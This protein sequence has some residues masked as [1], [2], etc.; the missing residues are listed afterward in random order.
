MVRK[1]RNRNS[2]GS[3]VLMVSGLLLIL[4]AIGWY[5]FSGALR[6][7]GAA[8]ITPTNEDNYPQIARI[9]PEDAKRAYDQGAAIFLDVRSVEEYNQERIRGALSI[10]LLELPERLGELDPNIWY[11]TYC[12]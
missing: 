3:L 12:T 1:K 8:Q 10:P 5:L 2:A 4:F 9:S 11:I 6:Q 7:S